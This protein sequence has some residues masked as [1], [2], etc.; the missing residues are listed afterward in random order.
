MV[1]LGH[2]ETACVFLSHER[3]MMYCPILLREFNTTYKRC[4]RVLHFTGDET[5]WGETEKCVI[6]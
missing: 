5:Q 3:G 2:R 4:M 1:S 6:S